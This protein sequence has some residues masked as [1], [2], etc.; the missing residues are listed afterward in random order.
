[1]AHYSNFV[2]LV[3]KDS[4]IILIEKSTYVIIY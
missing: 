4:I 2:L 3:L 1:M